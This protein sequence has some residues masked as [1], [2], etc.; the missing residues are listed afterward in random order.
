[1]ERKH[2]FDYYGTLGNTSFSSRNIDHWG[3]YN[4]S[5]TNNQSL[6]PGPLYTGGSQTTRDGSFYASTLGALRRIHYPTG[7]FTE[8]V[9]EPHD[10]SFLGNDTISLINTIVTYELDTVF[11]FSKSYLLVTTIQ[12]ITRL[13]SLLV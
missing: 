8:F 4:F 1:M 12:H 3:Y 5:G 2:S 7:G 9:Y 6:I 10:Y 13:L 11:T